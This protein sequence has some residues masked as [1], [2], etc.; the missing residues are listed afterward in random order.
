MDVFVKI[1]DVSLKKVYPSTLLNY[2][3]YSKK[4]S[5]LSENRN[6]P[7]MHNLDYLVFLQL[8]DRL[9]RILQLL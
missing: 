4:T 9:F 5:S 2:L 7:F 3:V 1:K 8:S 6:W